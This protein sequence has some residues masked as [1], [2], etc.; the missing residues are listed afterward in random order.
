M[1]VEAPKPSS[2]RYEI[3]GRLL[4]ETGLP[5]DRLHRFPS[6]LSGG[7]KQRVNIGR[8][9]CVMPEVVVADE[10]VSGLDVSIQAHILN[11]LLDL[12]R[13]H[14]I[15]VILISHDL[16]VVRYL[17]PRSLIMYRGEIVEEGLTDEIFD[18]PR[19]TYTRTLLAA[20]PQESVD[21]KRTA[22]AATAAQ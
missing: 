22:F 12:N 7:Q 20:I 19:H 11:L 10:I 17:C 13:R 5:E 2:E 3:A 1:E 9:L 18:N 14:G 16:A 15:T 21:M 6:E 8:A 4:R